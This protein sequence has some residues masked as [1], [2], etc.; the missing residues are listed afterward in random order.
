[1]DS[2]IAQA[3]IPALQHTKLQG[4]EGAL[5][6]AKFPECEPMC[7]FCHDTL[8]QAAQTY[9]PLFNPCTHAATVHSRQG[10]AGATHVLLFLPSHILCTSS[11]QRVYVGST[12]S[13]QLV[14]ISCTYS[15]FLR[16][17]VTF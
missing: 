10:Q 7:C 6:L 11:V 14:N 12:A 17:A 8:E 13:V 3:I 5:S 16:M 4:Y 2:L 1:M 9:A 15:V